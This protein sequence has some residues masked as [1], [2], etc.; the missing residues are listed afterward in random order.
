MGPFLPL[1]EGREVKI[2]HRFL[3][4]AL[5]LFHFADLD[6]LAQRLDVVALAFRFGEHFLDVVH[7]RG[8]VFLKALDALSKG[9]I[10]EIKNFKTPPPL[11]Q[12]VMEC[13]CVL[14]GAKTDWDSAKKVLG[15]S[16]F[17]N[18]L[19]NYDKDNIDKKIIKQVIKYYDNPDFTPEVVE[20]VSTAARP[21]CMWCRAMKVYDEVAKVVEPKKELLAKNTARLETGQGKLKGVRDELAAVVSKVEDLQNMC[22][23]TV[24]EK[25]RLQEAAE[26]TSKRLQRAGK[27]TTGLADE[28]V[29]WSTSVTDMTQARKDL[30]G[31][32]FLSAA[33]IAYCGPLIN[34]QLATD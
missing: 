25:Q 5:R 4:L 9:D 15:D 29:R 3:L 22:D 8:L 10:V 34:D 21:L 30:V 26:T 14:L 16:Q 17:M 24:A 31:D 11:V 2:E 18:R 1:A 20:R 6:D 19:L 12:K 27:L 23:R 32:V 7:H 13:V 28:A 33:F